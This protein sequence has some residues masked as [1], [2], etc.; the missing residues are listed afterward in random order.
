MPRANQDFLN[1]AFPLFPCCQWCLKQ[2]TRDS[3]T[4]D[5]LCPKSRGGTNDWSNM[6]IS[7]YNCNHNRGNKRIISRKGSWV[8]NR[9]AKP[10]G[11]LWL[12]PRRRL[13][14]LLPKDYWC[15]CH[16][17]T[18]KVSATQKEF[19]V[20]Q[21]FVCDSPIKTP[22]CDH[23]IAKAITEWLSDTITNASVHVYCSNESGLDRMTINYE[24]Y[25]KEP[26]I[27]NSRYYDIDD[28]KR[29]LPL[30]LVVALEKLNIS[31]II[32]E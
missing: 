9:V 14:K 25:G 15:D 13:D 31:S 8:S 3:A 19:D 18:M 7:C 16:G 2:L 21:L 20:F 24:P 17:I 6:V 28:V 22:F 27:Y 30:D 10:H 4:A 23:A 32:L 29:S 1:Y 11:P 5:H 12:G 26:E